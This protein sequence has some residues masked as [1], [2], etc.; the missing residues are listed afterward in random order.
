L[1]KI[2]V[3]SSDFEQHGSKNYWGAESLIAVG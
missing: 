1:V 2:C 3:N